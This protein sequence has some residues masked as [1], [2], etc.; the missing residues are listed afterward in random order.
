[1][2]QKA[3]R[4]ANGHAHLQGDQ[5]CIDLEA[6]SKDLNVR[7]HAEAAAAWHQRFEPLYAKREEAPNTLPSSLA[8]QVKAAD[9][10]AA[11]NAAA[12]Q[13]RSQGS[14]WH[15]TEGFQS[16]MCVRPGLPGHAIS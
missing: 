14:V 2:Q 1:M 15:G 16:C 13:V 8:G 7:K 12:A 11:A 3:K 9:A 4:I 10:Q 5:K 6:G